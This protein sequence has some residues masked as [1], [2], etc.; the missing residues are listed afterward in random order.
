MDDLRIPRGERGTSLVEVM[1][2]LAIVVTLGSAFAAS[3]R[4]MAPVYRWDQGTREVVQ[5]LREARQYAIAKNATVNVQLAADQMTVVDHSNGDAEI[6]VALLPQGVVLDGLP[7]D[8]DT[9]TFTPRSTC[10]GPSS[11]KVLGNGAAE[12]RNITLIKATGRVLAK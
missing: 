5:T 2:T 10:N 4:N 11:I 6:L 8:G 3:V 12:P 1:I 7:A 9:V